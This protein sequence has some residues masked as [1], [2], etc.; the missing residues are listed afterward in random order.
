MVCSNPKFGTGHNFSF[1]GKDHGLF[2]A[3][4]LLSK[5]GRKWTFDFNTSSERPLSIYVIGPM[6]VQHL[7]LGES[8]LH[9]ELCL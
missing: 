9:F 2:I 1:S 6:T 5:T 3:H 4:G 8:S 7:T